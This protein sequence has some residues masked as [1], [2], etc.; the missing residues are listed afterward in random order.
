M[1]LWV[2]VVRMGAHMDW[3]GQ[4]HWGVGPGEVVE[5]IF[6]WTFHQ[7]EGITCAQRYRPEA[8][9]EQLRAFGGFVL[10]N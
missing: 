8:S 10:V 2:V 5:E 9:K 4:L 1:Q 3:E 7:E 6:R